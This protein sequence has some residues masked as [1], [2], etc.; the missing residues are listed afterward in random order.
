MGWRRARPSESAARSGAH[1]STG[2]AAAHTLQELVQCLR[3]ADD[4]EHV[5]IPVGHESDIDGRQRLNFGS[6]SMRSC[7]LGRAVPLTTRVALAPQGQPTC[8]SDCLPG[9]ERVSRRPPAGSRAA[10]E[11]LARLGRRLGGLH[12]D[13]LVLSVRTL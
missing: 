2:P 9:S 5:V 1:V 10:A 4:D 13:A 12:A 8:G 11:S 6:R 7:S 3:G